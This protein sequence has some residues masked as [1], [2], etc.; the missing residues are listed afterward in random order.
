LCGNAAFPFL[1]VRA[2]VDPTLQHKNRA[3]VLADGPEIVL[4]P[5][6]TRQGFRAPALTALDAPSGTTPAA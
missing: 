6:G 2:L 4:R 5:V 1:H 3:E